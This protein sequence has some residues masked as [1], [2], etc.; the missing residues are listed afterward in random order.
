MARRASRSKG[1]E[2]LL[3]PTAGGAGELRSRIRSWLVEAGV[4]ADSIRAGYQTAEGPVGLYLTNRRVIIEVKKGGGLSKGPHAE[5]TGSREGETAFG[6]LD[7]RLRAERSREGLHRGEDAPSKSWIG[8]VTDGRAW[9]A[10]EWG[11][12]PGG[13]G[14]SAARIEAWHGQA[15]DG[16]SIK[17]LARLLARAPVGKEWASADM[18]DILRG[19]R[20][21]LADA[22]ARSSGRREVLTRKELWRGQMR[23]A[24][25]ALEADAATGSGAGAPRRRE[26]AGGGTPDADEDEAPVAHIAAQ[27]APR[28]PDRPQE[29]EGEMFAAHIA[30]QEAPRPPDRPQEDEGEMF[31]AHTML[32]LAARMVSSR[33]DA[34]YGFAGWV[35]DDI[36]QKARDAIDGYDWDQH[37]GD[38]LRALYMRHMPARHRPPDGERR[39]PDWLAEAMCGAIIDDGFIGEQIRRFR[40]GRKVECVLDPACGSGTLL[41][42]AVRRIAESEP[43]R[44]SGMGRPDAARLA[45][46]T[47]RGIDVHP[48]A[49]EIARANMGRL[50]RAAADASPMIYQGNALLVTRPESTLLGAGGDDLPLTSPQ[51]RQFVLPR[52]LVESRADLA[53]FV[54]SAVDGA[55]PPDGPGRGA[56][57]RDGGRLA[58]PHARL[59][60]IAAEEGG[61]GGDWLW[62]ISNQAGAMALRASAGRIASNPPW[63]VYDRMHEGRRKDRVR[64]A[65]TERGLW[66]GGLITRFDY[67]ALFVDKCAEMY[68]AK[69]GGSG[70]VLPRS[71]IKGHMWSGLRAAAGDRLTAVWDVGGLAFQSSACVMFLGVDAGDR[72]L[73]G[74]GGA[75]I[76]DGDS[77]AVVLKKARWDAVPHGMDEKESEWLAWGVPLAGRG[78]SIAPQCL[79]WADSVRAAGGEARVVTRASRWPP[80]TSAGST[81]GSVPAHWVRGCISARDLYPFAAPSRTRCILPVEWGGEWAWDVRRLYNEFW[82]RAEGRYEAHLGDES[83]APATLEDRINRNNGIFDQL[84]RRGHAATYNRSGSSIRACAISGGE[85]VHDTLHYLACASREEA[86]FVVGI[87]NSGAMLPAFLAARRGAGDF[88]DHIWRA[89]PVPRYDGRNA[90]HRRLAALSGRAEAEASR[91]LMDMGPRRGRAAEAG[92]REAL[93]GSGVSAQ[94]DDVCREI[95]PD[96]AA[97]RAGTAVNGGGGGGRIRNE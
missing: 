8:A 88:A 64:R 1:E 31:V 90:L 52:R 86:R 59:A 94:I 27:E 34:R 37:G 43:V 81:A 51:G 26:W 4:P 60:R 56:A 76:R 71:A 96:Y 67:A 12:K 66:V 84:E 18:P 7:R 22:Y 78:A 54:R 53:G 29:D 45:S 80:W 17:S 10:W 61:S 93:A 24:S 40:S 16:G 55:G 5:G 97:G 77:W 47:V 39:I 62:H 23:A 6:Q 87:L 35:P 89:V 74:E 15:L 63:A 72:R 58:E 21:N 33:E 85:I 36:A 82:E 2:A 30:A 48:V 75:G 83:D 14:D 70:W 73:A 68:L 91:M 19:V 11:P 49:A 95:L 32:V 50:L 79:V 9:Y 65:A 69:G 46:L 25:D 13:A 20:R 28:Q 41:C 92:I 57:G 44:R 3:G 42:H 38:A